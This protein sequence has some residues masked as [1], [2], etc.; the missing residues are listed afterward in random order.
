MY[1]HRGKRVYDLFYCTREPIGLDRMKQAMWKIA[2]SGD[3]SFRDRFAGQDV[4]F[5]TAV[6][7]TSLRSDLLRQFAGQAVTIEAI[8]DY[9]IASTPFAS[10]H[11]KRSTLA[12]MQK[13]GLIT[14]PNQKRKNMYPDGT[15]V[16]FPPARDS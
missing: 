6:D 15:I 2:P 13:H 16:V 12:E 14:S 4:I 5:G 11:V 8:A 9:V 3:F 7:T 10:N 1:D